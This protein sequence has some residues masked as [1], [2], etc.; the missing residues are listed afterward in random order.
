MV[1]ATAARRH[2]VDVRAWLQDHGLGDYA[3]VFASND[4]DAEVLRTL[5]ADDLKELG[6]TSLGHRWPRRI[7]ES[8]STC[9]GSS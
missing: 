1:A 9:Q 7:H 2:L 3:E 8:D 4:I 6:V 5:T